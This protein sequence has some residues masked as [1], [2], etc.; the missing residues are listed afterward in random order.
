MKKT[1]RKPVLVKRELL[2]AV[3]AAPAASGR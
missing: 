1:Y 2:S 3:T